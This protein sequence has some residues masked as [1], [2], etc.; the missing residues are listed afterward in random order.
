MPS[1]VSGENSHPTTGRPDSVTTM[2]STG[3]VDPQA[4]RARGLQR[5]WDPRVWGTIIGAVGATVFVGASRD[6]LPGPWPS[7][8]VVLWGLGAVGYL[9][10]VFVVPRAFGEIKHVGASAGFVYLGSVAGMLLLNGFGTLP[11]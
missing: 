4:A 6:V 9:V 10:F 1:N 7:I 11:P 2:R 3:R 8:A 5:P